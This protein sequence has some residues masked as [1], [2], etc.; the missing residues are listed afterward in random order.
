AEQRESEQRVEAE[1]AQTEAARQRDLAQD[2]LLDSLIRET[3]S[4]VTIRPLGYRKELQDRVRLAL[5]LPKSGQRRDELRAEFTQGLG[6]P[7]GAEPV[8]VVW[9]PALTANDFVRMSLSPDGEWAAVL[10]LGHGL[11]IRETRTGKSVADF[12]GLELRG[13][14]DAWVFN[15]V[16]STDGRALYGIIRVAEE[17]AGPDAYAVAE[18]RRN[19]D[20]SWARRQRPSQ[21]VF[22]VRGTRE[23]V[24]AVQPAADKTFQVLN[25]ETGRSLGT[26]SPPQDE[27]RPWHA[28]ALAPKRGW[29]ALGT[30]PGVGGLSTAIEV[31]SL[32]GPPRHVRL[33]PISGVGQFLSACFSPDEKHLACTGE[34]G[35]VI[36]ETEE[37]RIVSQLFGY[38]LGGYSGGAFVGDGSTMAFLQGQHPGVRLVSLTSGAERHL[39]TRELVRDL[40]S[41]EDGSTLA[42]HSRQKISFVR[43]ADSRER[44]RLTGHLGGVTALEFSPDGRLIASTGKDGAVRFWD[45]A[46]GTLRQTVARPNAMGQTVGFSPDGRWLAVGDFQHQ[47]IQLFSVETGQEV[48]TLGE[49]RLDG[50][51]TWGCGFS[52]DGRRLV[53]VGLGGLR[54]WELVPVV[55]RTNPVPWEAR[56]L[57]NEEGYFRNLL[58]DPEGRWIAFAGVT[59]RTAWNH[60]I[61]IRSFDSKI[62]DGAAPAQPIWAV[63]STGV[64]PVRN[65]IVFTAFDENTQSR[66]EGERTL[67]FLNPATREI[68][69]SL[70]L[71]APG[72]RSSTYISNVRFS[73]D[74]SRL[75]AANHDGRRVNLY[76]V[77]SGRRLYS[78]PD[79][80]G[81]VWW[82]AWHP[83]GR[84]LAVTR[85][86]GDIS[87]WNLPEVEAAI[88]QAGLAP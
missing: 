46:S 36:Y 2:R 69:R 24:F 63:Q 80:T 74:G 87:I 19:P 59:N 7:L 72:E 66:D 47:Q 50:G 51:L 37:F 38:F 21:P 44:R 73:P 13:A 49:A 42:F 82:L 35:A 54:V 6:D 27:I 64:L 3:R 65:Q 4:I 30:S 8:E 77:A 32:S 84:R 11:A 20:G 53:A 33:E 10:R 58:F 62:V 5:E 70:S 9:E 67:H 83:D 71:L 29:I 86:N 75:A 23:G 85:E 18:W 16:F 76:D 52:P 61:L 45:A 57:M 55:E 1:A 28:A 43:L 31:W 12:T 60:Q 25:L 15:P 48:L 14:W 56:L 78:L 34:N 88:A 22:T 81:V 41:S 26:F 68:V 40:V 17:G 39:K 79:E